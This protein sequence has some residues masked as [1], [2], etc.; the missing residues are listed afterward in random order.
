MKRLLI[1]AALAAAFPITQ[2]HAAENELGPDKPFSFAA[3]WGRLPKNVVP[4]DYTLAIEPDIASHVVRGK[5]TV[6]LD[7]RDT[8]DTVQ[9]NSLN[10][11]LSEVR[12]DGK[13]VKRT[14]SDN[15]KQLTTITLTKPAKPGPHTLSFHFSGVL[16]NRPFGLYSQ[17]FDKPDG[18]KD[19]IVSSKF[20]ATDARRMFPCWDEPAFRTSFTLSATVPAAWAAVSNMP[21]AKRTV[22]GNRATVTFARTPK[23]P[24]YLL[25]F[26]AGDLAAVTD[27]GGKTA[28]SVWAVRGQEKDGAVAL[29]NARQILADYNDYFGVEFPLPKLDSIATPGG[30]TGAMEN[31]GAI[32]YNDQLL[33]VTPSSTISD[34]QNVYS[35]Q[36]HEMAHQW[37]GDLVTMG[38]WDDLWLNES[39]ASWRGEK[40]TDMR[41]PIWK[42]GELQDG[43]K[44]FAMDADARLTARAIRQHVNNELEARSAF[45]PQITYAKG[46]AVLRMFEAYLGQDVFRDGV[47]RYMKAHAFSNATSADLWNALD[48]ASGID[49]GAIAA[50]WTT[51]PGFPLVTA[52]ASCDA[53]NKRTLTLKQQRFLLQGEDKNGAV[54]SIPLQ[55]R[56]G[57]AA[58]PAA[59]LF[60]K[61]GQQVPAGQCG[62]ALSL[63]ADVVGYYRVAYDEA[64]QQANLAHFADLPSG[65]RIAL[66]DDQWALAQADAHRLPD[67][68]ALAAAMG[69]DFDERAWNQ[70][71]EALAAI[72]E[73]E[74][75]SKGHDA[76]AA[77]AR[78]VLKPLAD[79]LGWDGKP[80]ELPGAQ[81]LRRTALGDL[82]AWGDQAVIGEARRRFAA[83]IKDHS[84]LTPDDQGMVLG[85]VARNADAATFGQL[86][87]LAKAAKN[88]TEL[89]RYYVALMKV[90]EPELAR[91]AAEIALSNEIPP[92]A[93]ALRLRLVAVL[94]QENP[95]LAWQTFS[96]NPDALLTAYPQYGPMIISLQ[97]PQIFWNAVPLDTLE[98]WVRKR[99]PAAMRPNVERGMEVARFKLGEKIALVGAADAYLAG[100]TGKAMAQKE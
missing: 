59:V 57:S 53:A 90:R 55:V 81:K 98:A 35:V 80:D 52:T 93:A 5:E 43:N 7:F 38:W 66:L 33:L 99:T 78:S 27:G 39:F 85:I 61:N 77:Y 46:Q 16:E 1:G 8:T 67:Y 26:S 25:E 51:K 91:Q 28:L 49:V 68:L 64:T 36:A 71:T 79:R 65:D 2:G 89:E 4:A 17:S 31:W 3:A 45:D 14:D 29:A 22:K 96:E 62:E 10:Q 82:G 12:F 88:E 20:E 40:E 30:F 48:A 60:H 21:I 13:P 73:G 97:V 54:W 41:N 72:E 18:S 69:T 70:I 19:V 94:D 11:I 47:R 42:W 100:K 74:R 76:F 58:K 84:A 37:N 50:D 6:R 86:H 44:E 83:F 23:M 87:A 92:Q 56:S 95:A 32:T 24:T 63:N 9:F 75:G 15:D 34:R